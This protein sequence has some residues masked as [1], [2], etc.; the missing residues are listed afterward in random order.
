MAGWGDNREIWEYGFLIQA[1]H[2]SDSPFSPNNKDNRVRVKH[3]RQRRGEEVHGARIPHGNHDAGRSAAP[4]LF[5]S[6][7]LGQARNEQWQQPQQ[8][9]WWDG[10][11]V[12]LL[13][14]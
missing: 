9:L 8:P 4:Q 2:V 11:Y 12:Y 14:L 13:R 3:H 6:G 10:K 1:G 7:R 5:G